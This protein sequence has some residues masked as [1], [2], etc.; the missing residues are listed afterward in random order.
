LN[1]PINYPIKE[2]SIKT[3]LKASAIALGGAAAFSLPAQ[4][5]IVFNGGADSLSASA[6]FDLIGTQLTAVL[7]NTS[8]S[9]ALVPTNI[10]TAFFFNVTGGSSL[11]SPMSAISGG[12][13]YLKGVQ[14]S[15]AGTAI[16]GEWACAGVSQYGANAGIS[17]TGLGLF[18]PG[19]LFPPQ[20]DLSSPLSPDGLHMASLLQV[21]TS[22]RATL[23]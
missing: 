14:V 4:A 11:L 18:G 12:P 20:I 19:D 22:L 7:T 21:T 1:T 13:T 9:D 15:P 8:A 3:S 2:Y 23:H 10:L 16:G 5:A 6:S 17:S